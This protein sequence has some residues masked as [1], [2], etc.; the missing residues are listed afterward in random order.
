[1]D[2]DDKGSILSLPITEAEVQPEIDDISD[3]DRSKEAE[4][5]ARTIIENL[6]DTVR[7]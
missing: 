5:V 2:S 3:E 4:R 7:P 6:L 1:M